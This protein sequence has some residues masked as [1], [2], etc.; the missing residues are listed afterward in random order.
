MSK[1]VMIPGLPF[2]IEEVNEDEQERKNRVGRRSGDGQVC[3]CGH[4]FNR[5]SE[6]RGTIVCQPTRMSCGC[7]DQVAALV[8]QD[9][10]VFLRKTVGV[11]IRHALTLG[12]KAAVEAGH[13]VEWVIPTGCSQCGA[14]K[15]FPVG[16]RRGVDGIRVVEDDDGTSPEATRLLCERCMGAIA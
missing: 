4:P 8:V 10:R 3:L 13:S 7:R 6:V 11:G 14:A 15:A 5:H 1:V 16:M 9:T 12:L 2:T